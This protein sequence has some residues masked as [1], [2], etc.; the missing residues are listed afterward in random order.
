MDSAE[1]AEK[2]CLK[3][4]TIQ[5]SCSSLSAF[6]ETQSHRPLFFTPL[7]AKSPVASVQPPR[8]GARPGNLWGVEIGRRVAEDAQR[9]NR[10]KQSTWMAV[11][12]SFCPTRQPSTRTRS[13]CVLVG[14]IS[15]DDRHQTMSA[16]V[17]PPPPRQTV[18]KIH[19]S[20]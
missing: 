7:R 10:F 6:S 16:W 20:V 3:I 14:E 17:P 19:F 4:P 11:L 18:I 2:D 12:T 9:Q 1:V 5:C 15:S 13:L 8:H